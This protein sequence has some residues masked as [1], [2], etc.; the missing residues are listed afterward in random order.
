VNLTE[1]RTGIAHLVR[2]AVGPNLP[3]YDAPPSNIAA[4][5]LIVSTGPAVAQPRRRAWDV[6]MRVSIVAP[7]GDNTAAV[8][9]LE[10]LIVQV[11]DVLSE[12]LTCP[13]TWDWPGQTTIGGNVYLIC[14]LTVPIHLETWPAPAPIGG[15]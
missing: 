13:V 1:H 11:A 3:V 14:Q 7:G 12:A 6:Q 9:T 4:P 10:T 2:D 5:C 8:T 15:S